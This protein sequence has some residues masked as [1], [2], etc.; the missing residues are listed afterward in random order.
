MKSEGTHFTRQL[1]GGGAWGGGGG[2][3]I[4]PCLF[5]LTGLS[6]VSLAGLQLADLPASASFMLGL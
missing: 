2:N 6:K 3:V 1:S 5:F 4:L